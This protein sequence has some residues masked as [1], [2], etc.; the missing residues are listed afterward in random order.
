MTVGR[1]LALVWVG[2]L[3]VPAVPVWAAEGD[4]TYLQSLIRE[5]HRKNLAERAQW[6]AFLHYEPTTLGGLESR[7]DDPDFFFADEGKTDPRAE[8]E[9]TLRAFFA[10]PTEAQPIEAGE[11]GRQH[12][13]CAFPARYHWLRGE[14]GFDPARLPERPCPRFEW[15]RDQLDAAGL[16]LVFPAAYMNNPSSMFGHTLLRLDQPDQTPD[17]RMLAYAI[18]YA[19]ETGDDGGMLFAVKGLTGF[20]PGHFSIAPYYEKVKLYSDLESRDIWEYPVSMDQ[21][22]LDRLVRHLW[23]L[24]GIRFDYYFFDENCSSQLLA[25][26]KAARPEL[27]LVSRFDY[28]AIPADTV[29]AVREETGLRAE[30]VYRPSLATRITHWAGQLRRRQQVTAR[31]IAEGRLMPD[32]ERLTGLPPKPRAR[33]LELAYHYLRYLKADGERSREEAADIG[34]ALLVRRSRLE[35]GAREKG[36]PAPQVRPDRGHASARVQ[37]GAGVR[38]GY[39]FQEV[40]LRPAFHDLLDPQGGYVDGAQIDLFGITVRRYSADGRTELHRFSVADIFSLT[41]RDRFRQSIS[42]KV[43]TALDRYPLEPK[44]GDFGERPW[45]WRSNGGAGLAW[46]LGSGG[47]VYAFLEGTADVSGSL[48][49]AVALGAGPALGLI[50]DPLPGWRVHLRGR[51]QRFALGETFTE[52]SYHLDQRVTLARN[53]ALKLKAAR[54]HLFGRW[55]NEAILEWAWYV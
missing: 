38:R 13:Q 47:L 9:A 39:G 42:W 53:H 11:T 3:L 22:E 25:L 19:A 33:T 27:R 5:A 20:Y 52:G 2:L 54:R 17:T 29:R 35:V 18:N 37:L 36:P 43:N 24:R 51:L 6:R 46:D 34:R 7:S 23:E 30:P 32:T 40:D 12:P 15:W 55:W 48:D 49:R 26:L 21:P 31:R 8:L 44:E 45:R 10:E 16:T 28:W 4:P 1:V 50:A 41:P 14:L